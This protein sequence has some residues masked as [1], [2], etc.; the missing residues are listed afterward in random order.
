M[1]LI[2]IKNY[3]QSIKVSNLFHLSTYFNMDPDIL[4][5]MLQH[6]E[7]KGCIRKSGKTDNCGTKCS[8]CSPLLTEIYEWVG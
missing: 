4:R 8:K 3:L 6:W 1:G 5:D 7:R 2:D